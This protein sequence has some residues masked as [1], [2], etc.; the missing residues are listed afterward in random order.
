MAG[1][2][3][4]AQDDRALSV[5]P[6]GRH[7]IDEAD[8]AAVTAVLR[9]DFLTTGPQVEAFE[10]DL[11]DVTGAAHALACSN[12]TAALHLAGLAL[13]MQPD[14]YVIVPSVTFLATANGP[15]LAGA[16]VWFAD[17]DSET[18][19]LGPSQLERSIS[20]AAKAWPNRRLRAVLPVH[21]NGQTCDISALAPMADKAGALLI[22]DACH[23]LGGVQYLA[24][25]RPEANADISVGAGHYT[26]MSVFS[27]HPVKTV[28]MGEG[29][30]ICSN[31]PR[32][33]RRIALLRNHGMERDPSRHEY[34]EQARDATGQPNPWYYEMPEVGLNYRAPDILCALGRSQLS[35][36][37]AFV[38]R[39][40]EL[41]ALYERLLLPLAP[42]VKPLARVQHGRAAWHLAV[43]LIDFPACG[44]E[45]GAVMHRLREQGIGSQVHYLPVHRQPYYRKRYG[46]ADLPGADAYYAK[47]LSLPLFSSLNEADIENVVAKLA[48][49]L[50]EGGVGQ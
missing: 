20:E 25:E 37:S 15:H 27:F 23:A 5:I 42:L 45:R 3:F 34:P 28:A 6:Y 49:I 9:G 21:L 18:G 50:H 43:A 31:D 8:I 24:G 14:D 44:M 22:E 36:L 32:L 16:E 19:L 48:A 4:P 30:A 2:G 11:R 12:G 39:R 13:E 10:A 40:T 29:G 46:L 7:N 1:W 17:V 35:K 47:C 38:R 33:A 26:A 41:A